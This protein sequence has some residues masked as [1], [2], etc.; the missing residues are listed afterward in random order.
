MVEK[1]AISYNVIELYFPHK[2]LANVL[3]LI[4]LSS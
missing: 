1:P 4:S 2:D 3:Y